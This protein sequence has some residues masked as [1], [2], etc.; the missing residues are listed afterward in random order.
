M[1]KSID[2]DIERLNDLGIR[3]E[4]QALNLSSQAV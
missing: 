4:A 3:A 2:P 1:T